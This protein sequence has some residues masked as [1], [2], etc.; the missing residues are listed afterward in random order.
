MFPR[1]RASLVSATV[2]VFR[3][4]RLVTK[5]FHACLTTVYADSHNTSRKMVLLETGATAHSVAAAAAA[6]YLVAG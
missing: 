6:A 5:S 3:A 2:P 4:V 1:R